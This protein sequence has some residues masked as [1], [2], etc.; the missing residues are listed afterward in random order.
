[1]REDRYNYECRIYQAKEYPTE[2][3]DVV[4]D[5]SDNGNYGFPYFAQKTKETDKGWKLKTKLYAALVHGWGCCCYVFNAHYPGGSNVTV[6]VLHHTL[7]TY[8][9]QGKALPPILSLQLDN[10]VKDN[11]QVQVSVRIPPRAY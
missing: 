10:T 6:N 3:M 1:M 2:V 5:G 9:Q 7:T 11:C 4:I 8:Q